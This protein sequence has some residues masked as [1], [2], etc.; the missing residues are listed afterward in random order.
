MHIDQKMCRAVLRPLVAI[1]LVTTGL[2]SSVLAM[3]APVVSETRR[4]EAAVTCTNLSSGASFQI[5]IDYDRNTV[6]TNPAQFSDRKISWRDA[7]LWNYTLDRKS[8][9]LTIVL[10]SSTGGSF[11]YDRCKLEN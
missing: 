5:K 8:G 9:D 1:Q 10:A 6:D 11:L 4:G 2:S 7:K 3:S